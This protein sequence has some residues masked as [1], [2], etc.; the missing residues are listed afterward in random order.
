MMNPC[1][2]NEEQPIKK[3][4]TGQKE[5]QRWLNKVIMHGQIY[6]L[7]DKGKLDSFKYSTESTNVF[8]AWFIY[9]DFS[10]R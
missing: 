3:K 4:N 9:R 6:F 5:L 2:G 10:K 7:T 1:G 8:P